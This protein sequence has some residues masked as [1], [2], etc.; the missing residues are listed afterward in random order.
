MSSL[1]LIHPDFQN[2][3][4]LGAAVL[5][6]SAVA[7]PLNSSESVKIVAMATISG[8]TT[9]LANYMMAYRGQKIKHLTVDKNW[10][11]AKAMTRFVRSDIP[12]VN[13]FWMSARDS[14]S[15]ALAGCVVACA[16][17]TPFPRLTVKLNARDFWFVF[18]LCSAI[19]LITSQ[20]MNKKIRDEIRQAEK[21]T[22]TSLELGPYFIGVASSALAL[23]SRVNRTIRQ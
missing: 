12:F 21:Q 19:T 6:F 11:S 20:L 1:S 14:V 4:Y 9:M 18:P 13:H 2:R 22:Q 10:G 7:L 16:A 23:T 8:F 15:F 17:R 5:A 3:C